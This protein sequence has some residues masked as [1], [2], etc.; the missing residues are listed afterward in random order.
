MWLADKEK[1]EAI[2]FPADFECGPHSSVE[3]ASF[4]PDAQ[5]LDLS[6]RA[7]RERIGLAYYRTFGI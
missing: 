7:I 1:I 6:E 4:L 2:P 5:W 3:P